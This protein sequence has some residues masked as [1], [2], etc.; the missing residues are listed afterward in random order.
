MKLITIEE[1]MAK[2]KE[3]TADL[4]EARAAI[5]EAR[6]AL[7][8]AKAALRAMEE[9]FDHLRA[10]LAR[11]ERLAD[12]NR[13]A[14]GEQTVNHHGELLDLDRLAE[15]QQQEHF[16]ICGTLYRRIPYGEEGPERAYVK[17]QGPMCRCGALLGH[18][19]LNGCQYE[20]CPRCRGQ[21]IAC[22][23]EDDPDAP[24]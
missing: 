8:E 14:T 3:T 22:S 20:D 4:E 24:P 10:R 5:K 12:P 16:L 17:T 7:K 6:A 11:L 15:D 23:C 13:P 2:V 18:R 19:H 21:C 9:K 1:A